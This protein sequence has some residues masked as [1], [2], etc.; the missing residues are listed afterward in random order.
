M[1]TNVYGG[2]GGGGGGGGG[3]SQAGIRERSTV[4]E[5]DQEGVLPVF[6][7]LALPLPPPPKP[8]S[9]VPVAAAVGCAC[10]KASERA[11]TMLPVR[12]NAASQ[13]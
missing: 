3:G 5:T 2:E 7:G 9:P 12:S 10:T 13:V 11:R 4:Y 8:P 6:E 1:Y